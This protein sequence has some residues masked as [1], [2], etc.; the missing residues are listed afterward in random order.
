MTDFPILQSLGF[1]LLTAAIAVVL[2]RAIRVPTIVA[3]MAAGLVL[4]P[5]AGVLTVT[6][7]VHLIAEVG[8]AL[9]LFLVGLELSLDKIRGVGRVALIVGGIQMA[10]TAFAGWLVATLFGL[11][12]GTA[13]VI[14]LSVTFSSTVVVV[15]LL[16]EKRDLGA[17]YGRISVGILLVQDIAV[18]IALTLFAG[19][20]TPEEATGV[21]SVVRGVALAFGG[22]FVLALAAAVAARWVLARVFA[23][24]RAS[25]ETVFIWSL[26]WCFLFILAAEAMHVSVELGAFIAGVGLAQL[27]FSEELRR[28]VQPLVNFFLAIF[29]VS[30]GLQMQPAAALARWPLV[31]ALCL[32]VVVVKP[33]VL[34]STIARLGYDGRTSFRSSMML[35]QMSEFCFIL[36]ALAA[37]A[38]ML[39]DEM[40]SV[41]SL[42]GLITIAISSYLVQFSDRMYDTVHDSRLL[43]IMGVTSVDEAEKES[44]LENHI[45]VIGMNTLGVRIVHQMAERGETVLAI[46]TDDGKL[47]GLPAETIMGSID[48]TSVLDEANFTHARLVISALQIEDT[49]NLLAYRCRTAGVPVSIHAFDPSLIDDLRE[50]GADHVIVPKHDGTRELARRL[51]QAG[52]LD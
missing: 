42:A 33:A 8:I 28:R 40:L 7:S 37:S 13:L 30:L 9:L 1:I 38:G 25:Q 36:A 47:A 2:L 14:A 27:H 39:P 41:I 49:N 18:A 51:R 22:M 32:T 31:L 44:S 17:M 19:L 45:V 43:R 12:L 6:E 34:L 26:A 15:K 46:D 21:A 35:A 16:G 5:V 50:M 23:W 11:P 10:A 24:I 20:Q 52:V 3:Y 48:D 4:G 29:F